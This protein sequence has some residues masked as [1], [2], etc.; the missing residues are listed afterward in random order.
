MIS[1][2]VLIVSKE[3]KDCSDFCQGLFLCRFISSTTNSLWYWRAQNYAWILIETYNQPPPE[4]ERG[5]RCRM[6]LKELFLLSF[7]Y[8]YSPRQYRCCP[9]MIDWLVDWLIVPFVLLLV[10]GDVVVNCFLI[11]TTYRKVDGGLVGHFYSR[12]SKTIIQ[13]EKENATLLLS[14]AL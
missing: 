9:W 8:Y 7:F 3:S 5:R 14:P 1:F 12:C 11:A 4:F 6:W 10:F 13:D 2:H